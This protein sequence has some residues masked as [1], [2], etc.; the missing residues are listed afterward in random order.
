MK[1]HPIIFST[2]MVQA[3]LEGRKTMT[4]RLNNLNTVND[5]PDNYNFLGL[6]VNAKSELFSTW[7]VKEFED[8]IFPNKFPYGNIGDKLWVKETFH[9]L[10]QADSFG[11]YLY[12]AMGDTPDKW[13]PSIFMPKEATRIWLEIIEIK[14]E[15]LQDISPDDACNEGV[16]YWNIDADALEGGELVADYENYD[17]KDDPKSYDYHFPTYSN[18]V[19]SFFSLWRKLNGMESLQANPWVWV[20]SF[21]KI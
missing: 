17:W 14:V 18:P 1:E 8:I 7:Q 16:N 5:K 19:D 21:K 9:K 3:I 10:K 20:I 13:K 15:R 12:K 11:K 2:P 6:E 4:R